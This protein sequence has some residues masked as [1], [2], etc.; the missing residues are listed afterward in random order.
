MA[1]VYLEEL[2]LDAPSRWTCSSTA[3]MDSWKTICCAGVG[4]TTLAR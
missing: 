2:L 1:T 4:Q 3:W